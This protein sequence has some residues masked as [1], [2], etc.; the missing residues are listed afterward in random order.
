MS[1]SSL[2]AVTLLLTACAAEAP[3]SPAAKADWQAAET[4]T[5]GLVDYRFVPDR[6]TFRRGV[7]YRLRLENRSSHQHEF[8][9]PGFFGAVAARN[10]EI[11]SKARPEIVV[12]PKQAKEFEFVPVAAGSYE[13]GCAD[14]D[15]AGMVGTIV[16]E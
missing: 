6:L 14:H 4:V 7:P 8:T 12:D 3:P 16:I 1:R 2:V 10:A 13:L 5:V 11:V 15:W 9:S